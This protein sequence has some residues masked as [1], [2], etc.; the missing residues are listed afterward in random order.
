MVLGQKVRI[1]NTE[2][3]KT[4]EPTHPVLPNNPEMK[5]LI[6]S[7]VEVYFY[8]I[9]Y[10]AKE[11]VPANEN[12]ILTAVSESHNPHSTTRH[13]SHTVSLPGISSS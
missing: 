11:K 7:R 3:K 4:K 12:L 9:A 2:Q 8:S 6:A 10:I 13:M 1:I 5:H